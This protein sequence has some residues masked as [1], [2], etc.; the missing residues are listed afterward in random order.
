MFSQNQTDVKLEWMYKGAQS[1]V[2]REDYLLG[3]SVDK[4]LEQ[5]NAQEKQQQQGLQPPKNHV[6]HECIPPSIRD[7]KEQIGEQVDINAKLQEDP[8]I[9]IKKQE[10]EKRRQFL[11]NPIQI[12]KLQRALKM[13]KN[14]KKKKHKRSKSDSEEEL[15]KK[16]A[17]KL[18][19]L[20]SAEILKSKS[21]KDGMLDTILMHKYNQLKS[22]LSQNDLTNILEGK[23]DKSSSESNS[24]SDASNSSS[25]KRRKERNI[26]YKH[27][28][29]RESTS[30]DEKKLS[31]KHTYKRLHSSE[32]QKKTY[33]DKTSNDDHNR[34]SYN[35]QN[36]ESSSSSSRKF[37]SRQEHRSDDRESFTK[38]KPEDNRY[39]SSSESDTG[40]RKRSWGLVRADGTKIPLVKSSSDKM[41]QPKLDKSKEQSKSYRKRE[42]LTEEEK[43]KRRQEMMQNAL[44]RDKERANNLKIYRESKS[45]EESQKDYNPDFLNK[46]LL[47]SANNSSVESRIK[48]NI[49]NIQRFGNDMTRHFSRR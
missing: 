4:G 8:L 38:K 44:W 12:K 35:S 7:Y 29:R 30:E 11:N 3:K 22:H 34:R 20:K 47:K 27:K 13:Q 18:K 24:D 25:D 10:E 48:S 16:L 42:R 32:S 23:K 45:K 14:I 43:E 6:E 37:V 46:E 36:Q 40:L 15:E 19:S 9:A 39:Q 28:N 2:D 26:K 1:S 49:N 33:R 41:Q 31:R 17:K 21:S 5:L